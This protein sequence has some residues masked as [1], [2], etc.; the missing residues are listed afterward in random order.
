MKPKPRHLGGEYAQQFQDTSIA[1]AY[2]HRPPYSEEAIHTLLRLLTEQPRTILDVG[3]GTGDVARKLAAD[4]AIERVDAVDFS[5][6]MLNIGK[7]LPGGDQPRLH[8]IYGRVEEVTLQPPYSLITAG[9]SLHWMDWSVIFPRFRQVLT[10]H[11]YLAIVG[12]NGERNPWDAALQLLINRYSTNKDFRP[13]NFITE[14]TQRQLFQ[15]HG[16]YNTQPVPF[17]QTVD[18]YIESFHSRNGFSRERM[19]QE[20]ANDFDNEARK[21]IS[22]F[23]Q[24]GNITLTVTCEIIWGVPL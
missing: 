4:K 7:T 23:Q 11:G 2:H 24:D 16:A 5:E 1:A 3:C 15:Q 13:Y 9:E 10:P 12:R 20:A 17:V 18:D 8:W 14:I 22:P 6:A 21:V 19:G